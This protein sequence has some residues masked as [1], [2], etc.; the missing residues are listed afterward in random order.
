MF[1]H[2]HN[3]VELAAIAIEQNYTLSLV[4]ACMHDINIL[5]ATV[6]YGTGMSYTSS[7][8]CIGYEQKLLNCR[9]IGPMSTPTCYYIAGIQCR[10]ETLC[11]AIQNR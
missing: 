1:F 5:G 7:V 4:T 6:Q 2:H 10:I 9:H 8:T 3:S 11:K